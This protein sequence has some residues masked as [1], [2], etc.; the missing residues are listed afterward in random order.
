[1]VVVRC[2]YTLMTRREKEKEKKEKKR[3]E[4]KKKNRNGKRL[5]MGRETA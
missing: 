5:D 2:V 3:R 1:M 4:A